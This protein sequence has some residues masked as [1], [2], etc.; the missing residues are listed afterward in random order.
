MGLDMYLTQQIYVKNWDWIKDED[1]KWEIT[2]KGPR[3]ESLDMSKLTYLE[4]SAITWRKANQIHAWFVKEI[5]DGEDNC[6]RYY[7]PTEKLT[8]LLEL[9]KKAKSIRGNKAG[10]LSLLPPESGFFFGSTEIDEWYWEYID[11]TIEQLEKLDLENGEYYYQSS[12]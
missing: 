7:V 11:F 4:F 5:Q 8:E 6:S 3:S 10:V 1:K 2:V 9:C 12:W